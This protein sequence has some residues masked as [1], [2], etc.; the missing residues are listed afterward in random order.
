PGRANPAA[1]A[2]EAAPRLDVRL[3]L[4]HQ[5]AHQ[6]A[7]TS[8]DLR[9]VERQPLVLRELER[10]R[11]QLGEPRR[12]AQL[13]A[14]A[15]HAAEQRGLVPHAD[16]L[17]LD[18]GA[19]RTREVPHELTEV[20]ALL[21]REIDDELVAVE[22]PFG[23]RH[24]H[25]EL[26]LLYERASLHADPVL[27]VPERVE[28]PHLVGPCLPQH[29]VLRRRGRAAARRR[30]LPL[31]DRPDRGYQPEVLAPV[32]LH[33]DV[34]A[35]A[36]VHAGVA[37]VRLARALEPDLR[38]SGH[39]SRPPATRRWPRT[40]PSV[41][42]GARLQR[43]ARAPPRCERARSPDGSRPGPNPRG[44]HPP[45]PAR[46]RRRRRAGGGLERSA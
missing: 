42:A 19:E 16:L 20:D 2:R 35:R 37:E 21:G 6:T 3:V 25:A 8:A 44:H 17:Q 22:L 28:P 30:A 31:R 38:E 45:A 4:V 5:A 26:V 24:L 10:Y 43:D 15:A 41:V 33:D 27:V 32:R 29:A 7:A 39:A 34:L 1:L 13:S 23:F 18:P 14:A 46:S 9:R 40:W 11:L 12:A 36:H